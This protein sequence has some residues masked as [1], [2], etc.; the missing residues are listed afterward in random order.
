MDAIAFHGDI[1][2]LVK[3]ENFL[4]R[5]EHARYTRFPLTFGHGVHGFEDFDGAGEGV[6]LDAADERLP[7]AH[8]GVDVVGVTDLAAAF[9]RRRTRAVF[10]QR[11]ERE[12]VDSCIGQHDKSLMLF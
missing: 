9:T 11:L 1:E 3:F 7:V 5:S 12:S 2:L 4:T 10:F 8:A 6:A